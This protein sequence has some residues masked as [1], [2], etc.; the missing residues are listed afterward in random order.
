M[1]IQREQLGLLLRNSLE[2]LS[3][4]NGRSWHS[5]SKLLQQVQGIGQVGSNSLFNAGIRSIDAIKLAEDSR[6]EI[7]LKRNPPFG[8]NIKKS[9]IESFPSVDFN[10]EIKDGIMKIYLKS[11]NMTASF[12]GKQVHLLVIAYANPSSCRTLLYDQIPLAILGAPLNRTISIQSCTELSFSCS[13]M[14]ENWSGLNQNICFEIENHKIA[15]FK[16]TCADER[17][18]VAPVRKSDIDL[19][20]DFEFE[21][22]NQLKSLN[23]NETLNHHTN[24]PPLSPMSTESQT[25]SKTTAAPKISSNSSCKHT[26]KDKFNC[27]HICCK[28]GLLKRAAETVLTPQSTKKPSFLSG[29]KRSLANAREY[30]RKYQPINIA[31]SSRVNIISNLQPTIDES[32]LYDEI[33]IALR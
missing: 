8:R 33:E 17:E 18:T 9:V 23:N 30:L 32:N 25:P 10:C 3:S 11:L 24:I 28:S 29:A 2:F 27:A 19:P 16:D 26:C 4:L 15:D 12:H 21:D 13:I 5:N 7:L 22:N 31:G 6:L 1:A 14:F 20:L